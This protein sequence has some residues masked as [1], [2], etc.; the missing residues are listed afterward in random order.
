MAD[1]SVFKTQAPKTKKE[2]EE[3]NG[4]RKKLTRVVKSKGREIENS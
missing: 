3:E 2:Q 4:L 1:D